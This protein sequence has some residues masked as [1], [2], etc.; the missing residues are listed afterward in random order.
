MSVYHL[1][2]PGGQYTSPAYMGLEALQ[3]PD[4]EKT[5]VLTDEE[6]ADGTVLTEE[7][8]Q[9]WLDVEIKRNREQRKPQEE[10][11][12]DFYAGWDNV[13]YRFVEEGGDSP[14]G[15]ASGEVLARPGKEREEMAVSEEQVAFLC[16][17]GNL[18]GAENISGPESVSGMENTSGP[19]KASETENV[20]D[21]GRTAE[22]YW[23]QSFAGIGSEAPESV[24]K[25]WIEAAEKA[26]VDGMGVSR[27]GKLSHLSKMMIQQCLRWQ[28]GE[29]SSNLLGNSV[30][31]AINAAE[32][33][34][35]ELEHPSEPERVPSPGKRQNIAKEKQFYIEFLNRLQALQEE[36]T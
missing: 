20:S 27:N 12:E 22:E 17:D 8:L 11:T 25:A 29:N 23:E 28:R 21:A 35:Y 5:D 7:E 13:K 9:R 26:G 14:Y 18:S 10:K 30:Q 3:P 2:M 1:G 24:K 31:S 34:L 6:P 15:D 36:G 4:R 16:R 33:A 32:R 19:E